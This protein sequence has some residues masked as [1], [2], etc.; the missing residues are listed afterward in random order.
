MTHLPICFLVVPN[1]LLEAIGWLGTISY[2]V[3]YLLLSMNKMKA[4]K[5]PY[6]MLNLIGA[7]GLIIHSGYLKDYPNITVNIAWAVIAAGSCFFIIR[8]QVTRKG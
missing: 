7:L 3:A 6:Q 8:K 1:P 2:L 5:L 4:T